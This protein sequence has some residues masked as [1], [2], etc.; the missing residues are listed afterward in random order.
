MCSTFRL[1]LN[2]YTLQYLYLHYLW[3]SA[4]KLLV[5]IPHSSFLWSL[6]F[7]CR[8]CECVSGSLDLICNLAEFHSCTWCIFLEEEFEG[9][10]L[11]QGEALRDGLN[12]DSWC[13][14]ILP[15]VS[16]KL[17][18]FNDLPELFFWS[19]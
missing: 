17:K 8:A 15:Y 6:W 1:S 10:L 2:P 18:K 14:H 9:Y 5:W 19:A 12:P 4:G 11:L 13:V 7:R 3:E 16:V